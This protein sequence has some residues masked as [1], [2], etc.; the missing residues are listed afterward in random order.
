MPEAGLGEKVDRPGI[1]DP[2]QKGGGAADD[3]NY[4]RSGAVSPSTDGV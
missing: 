3:D 1:S 4:A 2:W